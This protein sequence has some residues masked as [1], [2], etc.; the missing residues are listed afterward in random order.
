MC[1]R[2][3]CD[4]ETDEPRDPMPP[5]LVLVYALTMIVVILGVASLGGM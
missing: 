4:T 2:C 5:W 1:S 3:F